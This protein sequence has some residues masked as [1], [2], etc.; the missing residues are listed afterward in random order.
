MYFIFD[1][2]KSTYYNII[3]Y[4]LSNYFSVKALL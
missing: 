1:I 3:Y 2:L 4:F